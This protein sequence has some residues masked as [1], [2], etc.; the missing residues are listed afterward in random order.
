MQLAVRIGIVVFGLLVLFAGYE[1]ATRPNGP[2]EVLQ[3][4]LAVSKHLAQQAVDLLGTEH[5]WSDASIDKIDL[6][7]YVLTLHYTER[8][9]LP[10]VDKETKSVVTAILY[11]LTLSSHH[12][13]DEQTEIVVQARYGVG[14]ETLG[15]SH[16]DFR[17][18]TVVFDTQDG[19]P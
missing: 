14:S 13:T 8:P 1:A 10:T 5:Q 3:A 17:H 18:D 6:N 4:Q 16:Y 15:A 2:P 9:D 12:P 11:Q 7:G 19:Q